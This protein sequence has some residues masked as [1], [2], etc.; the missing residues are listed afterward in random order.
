MC[1]TRAARTYFVDVEARGLSPSGRTVVA[2]PS[3]Y[4]VSPTPCRTCR[5]AA[6]ASPRYRRLILCWPGIAARRRP[7]GTAS[8]RS[9]R[10]VARDRGGRVAGHGGEEG[11]AMEDAHAQ[12]AVRGAR[13]VAVRGCSRNRAISPKQSLRRASCHASARTTR[14]P[15]RRRRSSRRL[16]LLE[17]RCRCAT[18]R[19]EPATSSRSPRERAAAHPRDPVAQQHLPDFASGPAATAWCAAAADVPD[20]RAVGE[21]ALEQSELELLAQDPAHG[22]V[23]AGLEYAARPDL[24]EQCGDE[25]PCSRWAPSS[26]RGP[27]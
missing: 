1:L 7:L 17:H 25:V 16:A 11:A 9:S 18:R 27:R 6:R 4:G 8:S 14:P 23:D 20:I 10:L 2:E 22:V 3:E 12:A 13:T 24:G 21:G 15:A 5:P 26:C 19:L